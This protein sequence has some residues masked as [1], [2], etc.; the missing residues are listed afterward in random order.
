M[1]DQYMS[2]K[3][4]IIGSGFSSISAACY[5]AHEGYEVHVYEKNDQ[6]GGRARQ[7]V[8]DG[9]KFDM[10]PTWYWMPDVFDRFFNDW[11]KDFSIL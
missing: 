1:N 7:F 11:Q 10:G 5:L 9:F 3:V 8:R 4:S 6:L 2:K